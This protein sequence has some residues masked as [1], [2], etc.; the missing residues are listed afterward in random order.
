MS[1]F[2]ISPGWKIFVALRCGAWRCEAPRGAALRREARGKLP[3][4]LIR[5]M[6]SQFGLY[7]SY[8]KGI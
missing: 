8:I 6:P 1:L 3:Y 2:D 5:P 7:E 4:H